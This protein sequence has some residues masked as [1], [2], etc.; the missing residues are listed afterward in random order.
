MDSNKLVSCA[1]EIYRHQHVSM[2]EFVRTTQ[3]D[4][5]Y[6]YQSAALCLLRAID[7]AN[8][9][10]IMRWFL[11]YQAIVMENKSTKQTPSDKWWNDGKYFKWIQSYPKVS[12]RNMNS[13]VIKIAIDGY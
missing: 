2:N 3:N 4:V 8:K 11:K 10:P 7:V 12:I 13:Y 6:G 9:L 1:K 5:F